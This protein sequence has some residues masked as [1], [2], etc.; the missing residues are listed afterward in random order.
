MLVVIVAAF[1]AGATVRRIAGQRRSLTAGID[2]YVI[3]VALPALI[4]SKMSRATLGE[5]TIAPVVVAWITLVV[6]GAAIL[7][8]A[9]LRRWPARV[10]GSVLLVGVLGNTSFLGLGVTSALLGSD[11]LAAAISYDQLGSFLALA[12]VGSF[13][14]SRY[15]DGATGWR[16][17]AQRMITFAPF[18]ALMASPIVA[19]LDPH[20]LVYR[21]LDVPGATVGAAA[22]FSLGLRFSWSGWRERP[23]AVV[24]ALTAKMLLVPAIAVAIAVLVGDP[25]SVPWSAAVLQAAAPPMVTASLVAVSAGLDDKVASSSVCLGTLAACA[26]LPL[27]W[28]VI[29]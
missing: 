11:H 16:P 18:L 9:R 1:V 29:G 12:T 22:M 7:L 19:L 23:D 21:V 17:V 10:T 2:R 28:L 26:T 3:V 24:V 20:E 4:V 25:A 15:G 13:I 14:A 6:A 27:W 5:E 8:V